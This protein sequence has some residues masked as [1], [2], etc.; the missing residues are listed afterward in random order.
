M[1]PKSS[2]M[3]NFNMNIKNIFKMRLFK[4]K[5]AKVVTLPTGIKVVQY[6]NG[7]VEVL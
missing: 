3:K 6:I 1:K 2:I 7:R 4:R 5:I